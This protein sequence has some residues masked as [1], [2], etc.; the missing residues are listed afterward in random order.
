VGAGLWDARLNSENPPAFFF[1]AAASVSE[2]VPLPFAVAFFAFFG[3]GENRLQKGLAPFFVFDDGLSWTGTTCLVLFVATFFVATLALALALNLFGATFFGAAFFRAA[4]TLA[5]FNAAFFGLVPTRLKVTLPFAG[6]AAGG[7]SVVFSLGDAGLPLKKPTKG[8]DAAFPSFGT[9]GSSLGGASLPLKK[10]TEGNVAAFFS[11]GATG[12]SL[13][14]TS[15]PLKKPV[16]GNVAAS[17]SYGA[18]CS[19]LDGASLPLKARK[20]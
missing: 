12:S 2:T 3:V 7:G 14:G 11:F 13:G 1:G 8:N 4:L 10:R 18:T 16:K 15:L 5:G 19:S 6:G 20:G 9:T 17:P